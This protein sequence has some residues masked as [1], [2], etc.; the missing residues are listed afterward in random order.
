VGRGVRRTYYLLSRVEPYVGLEHGNQGRKPDRNFLFVV[1]SNMNRSMPS[2]SLIFRSVDRH[3]GHITVTTPQKTLL[4]RGN[5]LPRNLT[6][7]SPSERRQGCGRGKPQPL[8]PASAHSNPRTRLVV[9]SGLRAECARRN[10]GVSYRFC[11]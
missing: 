11:D 6:F 3:R 10:E 2:A 9:A 8:I 5:R 7:K 4:A 1:K